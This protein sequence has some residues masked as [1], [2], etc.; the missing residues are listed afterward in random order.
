MN[1]IGPKV[2]LTPGSISVAVDRLLEKGLVSRAENP[3]RVSKKLRLPQSHQ[4]KQAICNRGFTQFLTAV[5][6][7]PTKWHEYVV[8]SEEADVT[9]RFDPASTG[10]STFFGKQHIHLVRPDAVAAI[11]RFS[12]SS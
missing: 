4:F 12:N 10:L 5:K 11:H 1:T 7:C 2:H 6:T 3:T 8:R 9:I